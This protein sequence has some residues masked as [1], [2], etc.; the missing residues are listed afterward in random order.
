MNCVNEKFINFFSYQKPNFSPLR[1]NDDDDFFGHVELLF[2]VVIQ[3]F[4]Y[5]TFFFFGKGC[6]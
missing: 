4:S 2:V 5:L 1:H 6:V 3:Y